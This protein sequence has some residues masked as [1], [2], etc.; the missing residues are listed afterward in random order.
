V[1]VLGS[2]VAVLYFWV[3]CSVCV[4]LLDICAGA[5]SAFMCVGVFLFGSFNDFS[6]RLCSWVPIF[7]VVF[8]VVVG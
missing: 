4:V 3:V 1:R 2:V 7:L 5:I 8:I 6:T